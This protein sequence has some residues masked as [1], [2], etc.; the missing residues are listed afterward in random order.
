MQPPWC[1]LRNFMCGFFLWRRMLS[2]PWLFWMNW[3][4]VR[5][6]LLAP[7]NW[8]QSKY[9]SSLIYV[10]PPRAI[11]SCVWSYQGSGTHWLSF[12]YK[13]LWDKKLGKILSLTSLFWTSIAALGIFTTPNM[14]F[15]ANWYVKGWCKDS[16][17]LLLESDF[18]RW[19]SL[20]TLYHAND[21]L[22]TVTH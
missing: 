1:G 12:G 10:L 19:L 2:I 3:V 21:Q 18:G 22:P 8:I 13:T 9:H 17:I 5:R 14:S 20:R 15:T 16:L 11:A 4:A 7:R 6:Q